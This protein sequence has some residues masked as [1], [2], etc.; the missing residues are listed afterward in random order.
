M[1]SV[2]LSP[3]GEGALKSRHNAAGPGCI[4]RAGAGGR[5]TQ[6][7]S[8]IFS[9]YLLTIQNFFFNDVPPGVQEGRAKFY[10]ENGNSSRGP[11]TKCE[12]NCIGLGFKSAHPRAV[13]SPFALPPWET[14]LANFLTAEFSRPASF[15]FTKPLH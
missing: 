5:G 3:A 12:K 13:S 11:S 2:F 15:L 14:A 6:S 8:E 7:I 4:F 10:S 9:G 1:T